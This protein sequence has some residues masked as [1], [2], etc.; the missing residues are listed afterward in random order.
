MSHGG[1]F[2]KFNGLRTL[3]SNYVVGDSTYPGSPCL[4]HSHNKGGNDRCWRDSKTHSCLQCLD[5]IK[6]HQFGL[7][8]DRFSDEV[9]KQ[10]VK[11]W[12]N[13]D[14]TTYDD[15]WQWTKETKA[16]QLYYFWKRTDI[17][18]RYQWHPIAIAVWLSWGDTGS[19]GTE[20]LCGNRRCV[21]P[22]HNLPKGM[23]PSI[24]I[25]DYDSDWLE[26]QLLSLKSDVSSYL[27][28]QSNVLSNRSKAFVPQSDAF[29]VIGVDSDSLLY[30][31]NKALAATENQMA[32]GQHPMQLDC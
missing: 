1:A 19:L 7:S 15:C 22:L 16:K 5:K 9:R 17:R 14:I 2:R 13:V 12:S 30:S 23:I 24:R 3:K 4:Y 18:N 25:E 29:G 20:S 21:N 27:Q 8:L 28:A 26:S 32:I 10:A 6:K 31:F 11:F